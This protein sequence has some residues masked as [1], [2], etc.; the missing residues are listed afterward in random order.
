MFSYAAHRCAIDAHSWQTAL[1]DGN[2]RAAWASLV[3]FIDLNE[4]GSDPD[5]PDVD[6]S[7]ATMFAIASGGVDEAWTA[8]WLRERVRFGGIA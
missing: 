5:P 8:E 3:L 2:E 1:V 7:E 6:E 4:G